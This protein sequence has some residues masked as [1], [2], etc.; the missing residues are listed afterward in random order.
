MHEDHTT[1]HA[2]ARFVASCGWLT[3]LGGG[4]VLAMGLYG[5]SQTG[6]ICRL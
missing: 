2:I 5:F 1:T 6:F 4:G 3:V